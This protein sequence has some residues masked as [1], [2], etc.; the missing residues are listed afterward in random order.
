MN[1]A[2]LSIKKSTITWV[3]TILMVVGGAFSFFNL[4]WLEDPE[5]TIKDAIIMTPYP[6][7]SAAEVEEEVTNVLEK[8]VQELGQ[9][10]YV[11][12]RSSRGMSQIKVKIQDKYDASSLPQVWDEMRR[13]VNDYQVQLPPGAGPSNVNDDFGDV[14]G[15]Y[16]AITGEG[17]TDKELYEYAKFLQRELLHA[18]DVKRIDLYGVRDRKSVV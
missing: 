13:K 3:L 15:V 10:K 2:E 7:A 16:A 9:L 14:Y 1:I 12:S 11:E 5:F 18:E 4:A 6:G 8:A 17:Y